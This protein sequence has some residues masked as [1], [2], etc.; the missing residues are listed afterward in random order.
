MVLL[1]EKTADLTAIALRVRA[2]NHSCRLSA[3]RLAKSKGQASLRGATYD[4][5]NRLESCSRDPIGYEGSQWN[6][7][8]YVRSSSLRLTDP[9]GKAGI[10][11]PIR[12]SIL[13]AR[14]FDWRENIHR[15]AE[16]NCQNRCG[17][18]PKW[19]QEGC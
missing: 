19:C 16:M 13:G 1:A 17:L 10:L 15:R 2:Q 3:A 9:S 8:E 4:E 14:C 7:F 5:I 6:L 12:K 18:L 11:P